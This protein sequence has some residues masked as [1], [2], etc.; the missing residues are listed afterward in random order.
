MAE[1]NIID[2]LRSSAF[3]LGEVRD[4]LR[5]KAVP[6]VLE[7]RITRLCVIRGIRY[8][9]QFAEDSELEQF[10]QYVPEVSRALTA[11]A[12]MSNKIPSIPEARDRPY[13]IS[14]PQVAS[15]DTYRKLCQLC[16]AVSR[17]GSVAEEAR[18]SGSMEIFES[19]MRKPVRYRVTNDYTREIT[20]QDPTTACLNDDNAIVFT[21]DIDQGINK[22]RDEE[23]DPV[24]EGATVEESQDASDFDGMDYLY[25]FS[26]FD[27]KM[28]NI[29]EDINVGEV[30][31]EEPHLNYLPE[32]LF[33]PLPADLPQGN[34][35]LLILIAA[36]YG[37]SERYARL[38]R[39]RMIKGE[40]GCVVRGIYH[41][42][43]FS[44]WCATQTIPD[45]PAS[46][47]VTMAIHARMV[48]F[49]RM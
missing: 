38:H 18:A 22:P 40:P 28:F 23:R 31:S 32:L 35:D 16:G 24:I 45:W 47:H 29:T 8:H 21:L 26:G 4:A 5:G 15:Q 44:L 19:I 11:R 30:D 20:L 6:T 7:H 33:Q 3:D 37:N 48:V 25:P 10:R 17:D 14:H 49:L 36:Y 13:C 42:S 46:S 41:N 12:V 27:E 1:N 43:M 2:R 9:E 34:K 39:P